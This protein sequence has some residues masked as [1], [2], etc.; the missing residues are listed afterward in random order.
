MRTLR[1]LA[2]AAALSALFL[3]PYSVA[4]TDL[5]K[6]YTFGGQPDGENPGGVVAG[7][8]GVLYGATA[9]GGN[10]SYPGEG[11]V[12]A[13]QSPATQ[14]GAW[15]ETVLYAFS[16]GSVYFPVV[17]PVVGA[18]GALYGTTSFGGTGSGTVWELQ[19]AGAF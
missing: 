9:Y 4:Q 11:T 3:T 15:T 10:G 8:N 16:D 17:T 7:P 18:N 1:R 12:F 6:L 2:L 14:G 5:T 19:P 13:L